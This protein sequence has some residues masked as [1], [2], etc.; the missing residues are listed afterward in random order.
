MLKKN[1][2]SGE[3]GHL[4]NPAHL[5]LLAFSPGKIAS[6]MAQPVKNP[7]AVQETQGTPGFDPW[8]EKIPWR[9]AWQSTAVFLPG[10]SP[11][12]RGGWQAIVHGVTKSQTQLSD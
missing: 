5:Y 4:E 11:M 2:G 9:R 3:L 8:V 12:D 7:H 10:E 6:P 1:K